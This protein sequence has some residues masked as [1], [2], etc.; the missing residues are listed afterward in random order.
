[1][2]DVAA[3]DGV[4][5][6]GRYDRL[7]QGAHF[8]VKVQHVE[9]RH[10]VAADVAADALDVLVPTAAKGLVSGPRKHHHANVLALAADLH[11]VEHLHVGLRPKGIVD[12]L[13]V[14][15]D[16]GDA[17]KEFE[18]DVLV[19]LDDLPIARVAHDVV[20]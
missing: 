16:A 1:M 15:G 20:C 6:D 18:V 3:S 8:A 12:L 5:V 19:G 14:D 17:L 7:G 4:A 10:A 2:E 9:P 11:R 13:A